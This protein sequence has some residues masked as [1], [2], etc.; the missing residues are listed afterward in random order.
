MFVRECVCAFVCPFVRGW[1][2]LRVCVCICA[3]VC[4]CVRAFVCV[5]MFCVCVCVRVCAY[6]SVH[7]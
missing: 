1:V 2:S 5:H 3:F 4:M 7:A 6:G